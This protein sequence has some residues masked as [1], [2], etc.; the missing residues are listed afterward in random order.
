[1]SSSDSESSREKKEQLESYR[2]HMCNDADIADVF[3]LRL[4]P[5]L[6]R[7]RMNVPHAVELTDSDLQIPSKV[8]D[9]GEPRKSPYRAGALPTS[10]CAPGNG[11]NVVLVRAKTLW[12]S[13]LPNRSVRASIQSSDLK[14]APEQLYAWKASPDRRGQNSCKALRSSYE[15]FK[16]DRHPLA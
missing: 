8:A 12:K 7:R 2:I 13:R 14:T 5:P 16:L 11:H 9:I 10:G 3:D 15:P 6:S 4:M 1:M